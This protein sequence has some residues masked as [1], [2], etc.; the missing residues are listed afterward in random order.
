VPLVGHAQQVG[1][2]HRRQRMR[3]PLDEVEPAP[4]ELVEQPVG[5]L[6]DVGL[7]PGHRAGGE[8]PAHR[9]P[10]RGVHRRVVEDHPPG[11]QVARRFEAFTLLRGHVPLQRGDGV[12]GQALV[13]QRGDHVLVA[14]QQP[15]LVPTQPPD[16]TALAQPREQGMRVAHHLWGDKVDLRLRVGGLAHGLSSNISEHAVSSRPITPPP[17][18][19]CS[20][21]LPK[22]VEWV[23][24]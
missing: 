24:M 18:N 7:E 22:E 14:E 16:V 3:E 21:F 9:R 20:G 17:L 5:Q 13:V 2:H 19:D 6:G 12:G 15:R 4:V 23:P 10:Q 1:D 11:Q 8:R